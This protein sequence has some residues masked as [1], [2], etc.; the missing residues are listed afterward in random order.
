MAKYINDI[1]QK[2]SDSPDEWLVNP[3]FITLK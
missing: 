3:L 1:L 2:I